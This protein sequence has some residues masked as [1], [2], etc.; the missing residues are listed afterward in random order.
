MIIRTVQ[1]V[2][3]D[4]SSRFATEEAAST[5]A[6]APDSPPNR[7][8]PSLVGL[9]ELLNNF[10]DHVVEASRVIPNFPGIFSQAL[11]SSATSDL[12]ALRGAVDLARL[13][14]ANDD[15]ILF[16][17]ESTS[18]GERG[19]GSEKPPPARMVSSKEKNPVWHAPD[20]LIQMPTNKEAGLRS[21]GENLSAYLYNKWLKTKSMGRGVI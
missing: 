16:A 17:R 19:E 2:K 13:E 10:A 12:Y 1:D 7:A 4:M 5:G 18:F 11:A 20:Q 14:F 3:R 6:W 8:A 9:N 15:G 21:G